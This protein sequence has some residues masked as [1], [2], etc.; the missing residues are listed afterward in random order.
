MGQTM[1]TYITNCK[2]GS[3]ELKKSQLRQ[4]KTITDKGKRSNRDGCPDHKGVCIQ[5]KSLCGECGKYFY[6][7]LKGNVPENCTPCS[8]RLHRAYMWNKRREVAAGKH[9]EFA[10]RGDYC[11]IVSTC[12]QYPGCLDC[13]KFYPIFKGVDPG[14]M[15]QWT[16]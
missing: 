15:E 7:G 16:L 13:D 5:R 8:K 4:I 12:G 6:L 9:L 1:V 2:P 11:S 3:C 10:T 14:R